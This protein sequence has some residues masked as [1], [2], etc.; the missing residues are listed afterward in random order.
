M[1]LTARMEG[2]G[3]LGATLNGLDAEAHWED[4][5]RVRP[6]PALPCGQCRCLCTSR[7]PGG[8]DGSHGWA[9]DDVHR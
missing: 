1:P 4:V 6:R 8:S 5:Y 2:H 7:S 9:N 3:T